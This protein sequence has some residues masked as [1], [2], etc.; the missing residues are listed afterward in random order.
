MAVND[1][2]KIA[3]ATAMITISATP[4]APNLKSRSPTS[5]LGVMATI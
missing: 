1:Y 3:K 4:V 5:L 2:E